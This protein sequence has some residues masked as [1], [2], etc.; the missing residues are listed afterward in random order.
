MRHLS[1]LLPLLVA[2]AGPAGAQ[3]PANLAREAGV[4]ASSQASDADGKY[5]VKRLVD[6]DAN[7]HWASAGAALPQW[8]RLEWEAP[9]EIDTVTVALFTD[10][11]L[12][13]SWKRLEVETSDGAKAARDLGPAEQG[14]PILRLDKPHSVQWVKVSVLAVHEPKTYLGIN[15]VS[16]YLDPQQSIREPRPVPAPLPRGAVKVLG[17]RPHPTV[18]ANAADLERARRNAAGTV[19]GRSAKER[20]LAEAGKWLARTEEEWLRFLPQPGACYAYGFTGCPTC[21]S[22]FGTWGGARCS[23]EQPGKVT[24]VKGHTF[25]DAEHP[26]DG[27]GFKGPDGRVHYFIGSWNSWA[28][29]QWLTGILNLGHAYALTG[30]ERYAERAAFLLDAQAGIYAE[31]TSGS[32]DYPSSPPSGRFAR[33]WYQVARTLVPY[34]EAYD[35]IY[36]SKALDKPSLRPALEK[37][38]P[39]GPTAQMRAVKTPDVK[40]KSWEGMT[41]RENIDTNLMQD[42]AYYCYAETFHGMLHN[43]HADYMRGALAVGALLNIPEYVLNSVESPYSIYAMVTNNCDRDG[44][45]YE[46]SLGYALHCRELYLTFTEPLRHWRD[47]RYPNGVDLFANDRFRSFYLL[48]ELT[49]DVAGHP[50]NFGDCGPDH[51]YTPA[52]ETKFSAEDFMFAE[53]LMAGCS[54]AEKERFRRILLYLAGG[55]V[56]RTRAG[57][58]Q[59][60]WLLYHADP[61]AGA[62]NP[63]GTGT[64]S[65]AA[66]A[67]PADL[68]RKVFGSWFL[69]QKGLAIA[70]DGAG[71]DAQ[72]FLVRYGPSLNHGHLDDLGLV[73]YAKGWQNT[74]DIG[75]GLGSTH[76]QVGWCR[77]T[78]SHTLVMVNE[79]AQAGGSG[80]SLNLFARL[81]GLKIV[82]ADSPLSYAAQGVQQYRRTVALIGEGKDQ[83]LVDLFRVRGGKQH[84]YIVGS[85][86]Q[87]FTTAGVGFG[88]AQKGSLAGADIAW[89]EMQGIDGDMKGHPNKPYWNPPPGNGYGFLCGVRRGQPAGPW[90]V[91]W[92]LGGSNQARFRVHVL[93]DPMAK[94]AAEEAITA[95]APG[96]YPHNRNASYLLYRRKGED[97]DSTFASVMEP[98]ALSLPG[99]VLGY[100]DLQ[101]RTAETRGELV[102]MA[103]YSSLLLRGKQAG[104]FAAFTLAVPKDG[105]Y[106]LQ[107]RFLRSPSYGTARVL[108]DGRPVGEPWP[109][110]AATVEGPVPAVF[111][112]VSLKAG[113]HR[114]AVEMTDAQPRY[115]IGISALGLVPAA[116]A[117]PPATAPAPILAVVERLKVGGGTG[118]LSPAAVRVRRGDRDEFFAQAYSD[119]TE[120]VKSSIATPAGGLTWQGGAVYAAVRGGEPVALALCAGRQLEVA[121]ARVEAQTPLHGAKV[122]RVDYERNTVDVQPALPAAGLEGEAV[123]FANAKYSR[124]TAYRIERIEAIAG[125]SRIHLGTQSM[126]LGQGRIADRVD[127]HLLTTEVPHDYARSVVGSTNDGFFN[128]KRMVAETGAVTHLKEVI[129]GTPMRLAVENASAFRTGDVVRYYDVQEGDSL[130]IPTA[131]WLGLGEGNTWRLVSSVPVRLSGGVRVR[132]RGGQWAAP[133]GG[134]IPAT[135]MDGDA[136]VE[137]APKK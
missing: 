62:P 13:A 27:T 87:E 89:G 137:W 129:F 88:E 70:R 74:Y 76:T 86:G 72:G 58:A 5:G 117:A 126:V 103:S 77:Q 134:W 79:A 108:V 29:E 51:R 40:G 128:G 125:G 7:T 91:D 55:D 133:A 127:A 18:Y 9:Q 115:F 14:T 93:P 47:A 82:D 112:P 37:T 110:T 42:G 114:V 3:A 107:A 123:L 2:L 67:L 43:G 59:A 50:L 84:D 65:A 106:V 24:C 26:D 101:R 6:G 1:L 130:T 66:L 118:A 35:L 109:A 122:T 73:Y 57:S 105:D 12:Y 52:T 75:Y 53:H 54:G 46:T 100:Q 135:G 63:G 45:Y 116:Q 94:P 21:G 49:M 60:R 56:E 19:W 80:G 113:E 16:I 92:T 33:P 48:P 4:T 124:N 28:T 36:N 136:E 32:W 71:E 10:K 17:G 78:A 120:V 61:V 132:A 102:A 81:P 95:K 39:A 104:D 131:A 119:A 11:P 25:P 15:E 90:S 83:Y 111:G 98:Y 99:G 22:S 97:L 38:W 68:Q 44:R 34:V 64:A 23:W 31:S 96:V 30:E 20:T 85:Q 69:G 41:R 121:G 8:V